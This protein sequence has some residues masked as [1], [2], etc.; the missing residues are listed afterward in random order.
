[1]SGSQKNADKERPMDLNLK[2]TFL[3]RWEIYF[4]SAE[5]PVVS[6]YTHDSTLAEAAKPGKASHCVIA[7]LARARQG[8]PV[9][10]D[11][12]TV[13]CSGGKRYLGFSQSLRP[14]FEYFLSY[15]IE[16]EM[17]GER[18]KKTPEHVLNGM[19]NQPP[20]EAPAPY[21]MFKRW[22]TLG[23]IDQP[24]IAIFFATPDVLSGL[25]TL[26]N[27]DEY[28]ANAV[29]APMGSGCSSIVQ[30]P[31]RELESAHPRALLGMFDVSARPYVPADVLTLAVPWPKL[32]S[33]IENMPESFL[34]TGS[35]DKVRRRMAN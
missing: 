28:E 5:L 33:M 31:Y 1:M 20:F 26:A 35:W 2:A 22:D 32:V 34:I 6:Y 17:E 11:K 3:E 27:Y 13:G 18:Y 15:G 24:E 25:Y 4:P 14:N 30:N 16:G 9:C 29:I 23:E 10:L 19:L 21:L 7:Q 8:Q 12:A